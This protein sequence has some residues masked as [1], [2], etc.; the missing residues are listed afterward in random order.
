MAKSKSFIFIYKTKIS[1]LFLIKNRIL[2]GWLNA[3]E[4]HFELYLN[5]CLNAFDELDFGFILW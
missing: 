3:R 2:C 4:K 5:I 1:F